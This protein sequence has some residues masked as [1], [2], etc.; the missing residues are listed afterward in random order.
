MQTPPAFRMMEMPSTNEF[1]SATWARTLLPTTRS[2]W[3]PVSA[4]CTC[5]LNTKELH[6]SRHPALFSRLGN[7]CRRI[8]A[9]DRNALL[10]K[11]LQQIS[12]IAT[13]FND[14]ARRARGPIFSD[15]V[16]TYLPRMIEPA[17]GIGRKIGVFGKDLF[18]CNILLE[19]HEKTVAT[20]VCGKRIKR[21][22]CVELVF[23][24]IALTQWRHAEVNELGKGA[25]AETAIA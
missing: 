6:Q 24:E 19:L 14:P 4:N 3:V 8:D 16:S 23:C 2:A 18:R 12:V 9:E 22:H 15:I 13:E 21:L 25:T 5:R 1:R 10:D 17:I 11:E 20:N 7:V